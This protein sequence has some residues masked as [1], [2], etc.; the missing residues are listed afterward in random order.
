MN[1]FQK[2]RLLAH[3]AKWRLCWNSFD[4]HRQA[5]QHPKFKSPWDA[6]QLIQDN[7]VIATSGLAGNQRASVVFRAIRTCFEQTGHPKNLTV[8]STGGQGGFGIVPG[9][10]EEFASPGLCSRF[11]TGH[12]DTFRK[13]TALAENGQLEIHCL[14]QGIIAL[15]FAAQS[16]GQYTWLTSTGI[17]TFLD[18]RCGRGTPIF[19]PQAKQLVHVK[20]HQLEYELPKINVAILNAPAA[21]P[22]GNIYIKNCAMIGES[23]EIAA[24]AKRNGGL[25]IV[26]VGLLVEPGYDDVFLG[27]DMV[28]AIVLDP[29]T[30]QTG[31]VPHR[32]YWSFFTT[33]SQ[34][35][36]DQGIAHVS[37]ANRILGLTPKRTPIHRLI[38]KIA[39]DLLAHHIHPGAFVNIGTGLPEEVSRLL[40]EGG[41]ANQIT[42]FAESGVIGG[43][44][45]AGI[46]FGA[47]IHPR[48]I[49]SSPQVFELCYQNLDAAVFGVL[50]VDS[51]GNVNVSQKGETLH[52]YVGP[53]GFMDLS[54]NAKVVIF[55]STWMNHSRVAIQ[56]NRLKI[57]KYGEPKFVEHVH[58]ITFPGAK[59]LERGQKVFFVTEIGMFELTSKGMELKSI[60]PG[61][62][63]EKDILKTTRMKVILPEMG[64]PTM[65]AAIFSEKFKLHLRTLV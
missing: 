44:P 1:F 15:L 43:L 26:N 14:P 18:P 20:D 65:E 2:L 22:Q 63:L 51:N 42:L 57:L 64:L 55:V 49:I 60:M 7:S 6:A 41:L 9:T 12:F 37:L 54:S 16:K 38:A 62:D 59:A 53:G 4:V 45:A 24:A 21:D 36:M 34:Q 58:E 61:I 17:E 31:S 39:A 19:S 50:E 29:E 35:T 46:F 25:V 52:Q 11:I 47:S 33:Q 30:E 13:M 48:K 8:M 28:D 32:K 5:P 56:Q 10:V 27:P 3:F 23:R 40:Y